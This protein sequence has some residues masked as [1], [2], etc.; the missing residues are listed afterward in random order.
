M[1]RSFEDLES[2]LAGQD[3]ELERVAVAFE[4]LP[5]DARYEVPSS[6]FEELETTCA[7]R[8]IQTTQPIYGL[9]A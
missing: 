3:V 9:R 4:D 8:T 6:F 5:A 2:E 1:T 7:V